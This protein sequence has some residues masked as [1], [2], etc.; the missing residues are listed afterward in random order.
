VVWCVG[1][2]RDGRRTGKTETEE[3]N[4]GRRGE[5]SK[6]RGERSREEES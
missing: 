3:R 1:A 2:A 6:G 4:E 5:R